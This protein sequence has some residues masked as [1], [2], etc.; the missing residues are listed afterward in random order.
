MLTRCSNLTITALPSSKV[1]NLGFACF[2]LEIL[3][4][5]FALIVIFPTV[6]TA[7]CSLTIKFLSNVSTAIS[8]AIGALTHFPTSATCA[9]CIRGCIGRTV[10]FR[11]GAVSVFQLRGGDGDTFIF[12]FLYSLICSLL[13]TCLKDNLTCALAMNTST[14]GSSIEIAFACVHYAINTNRDIHK[15]GF[16]KC[17]FSTGCIR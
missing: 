1:G 8:A 13:T 6:S 16:L 9:I 14:A 7:G 4:A 2:I 3:A 12:C 10:G 17:I 11:I 5:V 15:I